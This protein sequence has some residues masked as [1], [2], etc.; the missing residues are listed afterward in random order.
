[1]LRVEQTSFC[2]ATVRTLILVPS[3]QRIHGI[4]CAYEKARSPG[5]ILYGSHRSC[6]VFLLS[7]GLLCL[8][9]TLLVLEWECGMSSSVF[10]WEKRWELRPFV[11]CLSIDVYCLAEGCG[12]LS[13]GPE[14]PDWTVTMVTLQ[15]DTFSSM[16]YVLLWLAFQVTVYLL[17]RERNA[18]RHRTSW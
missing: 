6:L 11:F 18:R 2:G 4:N 17:W 15:G 14:T 3:Q 13:W 8:I 16:V 1:M 7:L 5:H 12:K 9:V 10:C